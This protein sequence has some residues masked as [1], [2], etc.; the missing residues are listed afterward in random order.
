M[1]EMQARERIVEIA[2]TWLGTR[3]HHM[4][5]IKG[6]GADCLTFIAMVYQEASLIEDINIPFYHGD[7]MLHRS[8]E[9]YLEG[10]LQYSK[11]VKKPKKG[12]I[13]LWKFGRC[14]SHGSIIIDW[15]EIIH[16]YYHVGCNTDNVDNAGW[17][18]FIGNKP[19]PVR[20]FSLWG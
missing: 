20:F 1:E 3:Y 7:W 12:D 11:E 6:S 8:E 13:A 9:K 18:K 2:K 17:L 10:L 19:R 16:S 15:P 5:R 4:G 14:F